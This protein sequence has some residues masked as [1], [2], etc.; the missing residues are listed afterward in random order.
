M[1]E[2]KKRQAK[3]FDYLPLPKRKGPSFNETGLWIQIIN[4]SKPEYLT[5]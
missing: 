3:L 2:K 5:T 4:Y 1:A